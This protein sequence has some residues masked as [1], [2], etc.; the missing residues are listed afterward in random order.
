MID[1]FTKNDWQIY[2]LILAL[3]VGYHFYNESGDAYTLYR[4]SLGGDRV[5]V[6]TFD[7]KNESG[8]YNALNCNLA[9]SLFQNQPGVTM[10]Y[11]CEKGRFKK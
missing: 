10:R 11:W 5:H 8:E 2:F 6:A 1:F 9:A 7:A 3:L 4:F